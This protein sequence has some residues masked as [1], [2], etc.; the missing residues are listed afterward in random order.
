VTRITTA[1]E[2]NHS[3]TSVVSETMAKEGCGCDREKRSYSLFT[4]K[5]QTPQEW[6]KMPQE[7]RDLF[8]KVMSSLTASWAARTSTSKAGFSQHLRPRTR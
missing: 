1:G 3:G 5:I 8:T 6:H 2:P 7:Y 4:D